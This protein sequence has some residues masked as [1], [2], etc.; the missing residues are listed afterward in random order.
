VARNCVVLDVEDDN[1]HADITHGNQVS[2]FG[3]QFHLHTIIRED[4]F[5]GQKFADFDI[6]LSFSNLPTSICQRIAKKLGIDDNEIEDW[7]DC[8]RQQVQQH[9]KLHRNNT[10]KGLKNC[11]QR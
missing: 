11:F 4:I 6:D 7:W 9:L 1:E 3:E 10:I 8:T 2:K 5:I